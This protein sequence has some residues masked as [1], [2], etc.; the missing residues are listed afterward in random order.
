MVGIYCAG[1]HTK[2]V[3]ESLQRNEIPV[4]VVVDDN[5]A[6]TGSQIGDFTVRNPDEIDID[7]YDW[8]VANGT[9]LIREEIVERLNKAGATCRNF[10]DKDATVE[11]EPFDQAHIYISAQCYITGAVTFSEDILIDG[12]VYIGHHSEIGSHVT[13]GPNAT[14]GG[15]VTVGNRSFIGLGVNIREGVSIGGDT[16]IGAGATVVKDIPSNSFA[17][18]TPAEVVREIE[19]VTFDLLW[20]R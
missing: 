6:K 19:E 10:I 5:N 1:G 17:V 13:I 2:T 16:L 12:G 20:N 14:I 3:I 8:I 15:E 9:N 11:T 18:G 7:E 4:D